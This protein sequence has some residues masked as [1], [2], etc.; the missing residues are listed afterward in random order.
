[1]S[2]HPQ[3]P[4]DRPRQPQPRGQ[5]GLAAARA[6]R[7]VAALQRPPRARA[8][9][10]Q[11]RRPQPVVLWPSARLLPLAPCLFCSGRRR[12][13][14]RAASTCGSRQN[15]AAGCRLPRDG[16]YGRCEGEGGELRGQGTKRLAG[17]QA[18][19]F[20]PQLKHLF[21]SRGL[22]GSGGGTPSASAV[23]AACSRRGHFLAKWV[24]LWQTWHVFTALEATMHDTNNHKKNNP[25]PISLSTT[26]NHYYQIQICI[27]ETYLFL[28]LKFLS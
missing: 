13:C 5:R 28:Y 26:Q 10:R 23:A 8:W 20:C 18:S 19:P 9:A 22:S 27:S 1:M 14:G 25:P 15:A 12:A 7:A 21:S 11:P 16:L 17:H 6:L 4:G 24:G 3:Q 2:H